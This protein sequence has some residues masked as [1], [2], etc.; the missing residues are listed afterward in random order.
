M[1]ERVSITEQ[2]G[3]SLA[4]LLSEKI[5]TVYARFD[6]ES[7]VA[8]VAAGVP[9]KSY[10]ERIVF[11]A[12][13]LFT[14]LPDN[15]ED[16]TSIL[17]GILGDE[18]PKET[19]MFT[20]YWW[21][22]PIGKYVELYGLNNYEVSIKAIEEITKRNTGE[23]AIRPF[24][25]NYPERCLAQMKEWARSEDVHLRRLASEGLRPKLPWARK[26]DLFNDNPRPIFEIL[27]LLKA[28]EVMFVKKSVGNH[29]TDW[30]KVN[31]EPTRK[32]LQEWQTSPNKHTQWIVR[33]ATR[34]IA[35]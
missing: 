17:L 20:E 11:I 15:Y 24:I 18:N 3:E 7:F 30:L 28:D 25:R 32:L 5:Q 16:A 10:T 22:M 33:R 29:L 6:S 27:E 13:Q 12:Q 4:V 14:Y 1:V 9:N 26:L 21:I 31:Y 35:I 19:G 34:K 8:A 2:F 23:Y